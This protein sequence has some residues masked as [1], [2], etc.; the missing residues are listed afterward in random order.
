MKND[1]HALSVELQRDV[2]G[3]PPDGRDRFPVV[4]VIVPKM[5]RA[6]GGARCALISSGPDNAAA[7][8]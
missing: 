3:E 6:E 2:I 1:R 5:D 7:P 8:I 4:G